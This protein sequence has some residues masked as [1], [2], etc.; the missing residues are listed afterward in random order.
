MAVAVAIW[1]SDIGDRRTSLP[2]LSPNQP[3]YYMKEFA[4]TAFDA[5]G[6]AQHHLAA[7]HLAYFADKSAQLTQPKL[8]LIQ[9]GS[10]W[11]V[12][13]RDGTVRPDEHIELS[14]EVH[15]VHSDVDVDGG[16][17]FEVTTEAL[18]VDF[19]AGIAE[20]AMPVKLVHSQ[21][22]IEAQGM[23]LQFNSKTL[24]LR[25]K[26]RGYYDAH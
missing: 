5:S 12:V 9:D 14:R 4:L 13:A 19:A 11:E 7:D 23:W 16:T 1:L 8:R 25:K 22:W 15:V 17:G 24:N 26:V 3:I 10:Q 18:D 6:A 21:G 20:T 2:K